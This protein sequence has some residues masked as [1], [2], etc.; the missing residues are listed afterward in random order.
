MLDAL[1]LKNGN[2]CYSKNSISK[3]IKGACIHYRIFRHSTKHTIEDGSDLTVIKTI[4]G[5]AGGTIKWEGL[6]ITVS[7]NIVRIL[8]SRHVI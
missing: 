2:Y 8:E 1:T 4:S 6:D 5:K 3:A 7:E